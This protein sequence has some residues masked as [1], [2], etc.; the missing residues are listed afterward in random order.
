V[1]GTI[2]PPA[3]HHQCTITGWEF[4]LLG[5]Q[6]TLIELGGPMRRHRLAEGKGLREETVRG[7][8]KQIADPFAISTAV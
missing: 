1:R 6:W 8:V 3:V 7:K 4:Q 2:K 5:Y